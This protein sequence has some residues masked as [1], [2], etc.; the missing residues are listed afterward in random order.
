MRILS[1]FAY[2]AVVVCLFLNLVNGRSLRQPSFYVSRLLNDGEQL[3]VIHFGGVSVQETTAVVPVPASS[4]HLA[5]NESAEHVEGGSGLRLVQVTD[6]RHLVQAVFYADYKLKDCEYV[7]DKDAVNHFLDSLKSDFEAARKLIKSHSN[8][9]DEN[10]KVNTSYDGVINLKLLRHSSDLFPESRRLVDYKWIRNECRILHQKMKEVAHEAKLNGNLAARRKKRQLM[11]YP[12]T[13]WCGVGSATE[14]YND[15]GWNAAVDRCCRQH[16]HCPR[17][18][19]AFSKKYNYF[20]YR[21]HTL[22]ECECDERFRTCLKRVNNAPSN[23][24]GKLFFNVVQMKCFTL[25]SEETCIKKSWW[26]RCIKKGKQLQ[27]YERDVL[28]Y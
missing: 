13:N 14:G 3:R 28:T 21:F 5:T 4:S 9:P 23:L 6:G 17:I 8:T 1:N 27:A 7:R 18:I 25:K 22:S 2:Y 20:N 12:G 15:L 26:G 11:I 16:D 24:V 10:K 19:E